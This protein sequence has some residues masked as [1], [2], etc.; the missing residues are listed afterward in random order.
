MKR[1]LPTLLLLPLLVTVGRSA[2]AA[3][4]GLRLPAFPL[5][6]LVREAGAPKEMSSVRLL[7]ELHRESHSR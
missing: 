3:A 2:S 1:L 7:R 6:T 4:D 5:P